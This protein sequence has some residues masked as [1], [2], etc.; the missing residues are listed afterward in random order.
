MPPTTATATHGGQAPRGLTTTPSSDTKTGRFGRLFRNLPVFDIDDQTLI[1]LGRAMIQDLEA[2]QLD[3]PLGAED[4]DE[5]TALLEGTEELRLPAGYTYFGQFVDHDITFDPVSSLSAQDDPNALVD[6]R[7]PRFD[8]DNIY[9]RGPNDQPYM[10][11]PDGL[12]LTLGASVGEGPFGGP[13]LQRVASGRAIIGDPRNDENLIVSQLQSAVLRFHNAVVDQV[14][15]E[16]PAWSAADQLKLAQQIVRW[17]YQWIV[18]HDFLPRL[19]GQRVVDDILTSVS[20][21]IPGASDVSVVLKPNLRFF[22]WNGRPYMPVE[23]SV[24]AYRYGHSAVRPSYDINDVAKTDPPVLNAARIPLFDQTGQPRQSLNG[25]RPLPDSWGFQWKYFLPGITGSDPT[26]KRLPQPSY[27]IDETL[28]HPL[29]ALPEST[30]APEVVSAGFDPAIAQSLAIRNLLRG[31]RLSLPSGQDVALAMG[32]EPLSEEELYKDIALEPSVIGDLEGRAPL[33]YYV[34]REA[35]VLGKQEMLGPVGGRI[36]AEVFVGLL[37][38]DRLSYINVQPN[39]SPTLPG[40]VA[41]HFTLTDLINIAIPA[42]P[43]STPAQYSA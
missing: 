41:K 23:F 38:A 7:T 37:T 33:W 28:S 24:A 27:K 20:Y 8:L 9:G 3:K 35:H 15:G 22:H 21:T 4:D 43:A 42:L 5:N 18:V 39:W 11:E 10:Y 25:F 29:G 31:K 2:G 26:D 13:D 19:V 1:A 40:R 14:V 34:L 36:V 32:I 6:F 12:H 17:H 30:A 16:H